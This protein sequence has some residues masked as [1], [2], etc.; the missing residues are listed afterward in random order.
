MKLNEEDEQRITRWIDG[1]LSDSDVADLLSAH[2]ELADEK[3][4]ASALGDLLRQELQPDREADVPHA[5][6]FSH[7]L[8]QRILEDEAETAR[9]GGDSV[10]LREEAQI[11]PLFT[12]MRYAAGIAFLVMLVS[13]ISYGLFSSS[14]AIGSEVV[15]TYTP[16]PSVAATTRYS[17]AADATIIQL[18][19]IPEVPVDQSIAGV[20]PGS[21]QPCGDFGRTILTDHDNGHPLLALAIDGNGRP[22]FTALRF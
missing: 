2:P 16:D 9:A 22:E 7:R 19:G 3:N 15:S 17:A 10:S 21:Y 20:S 18:E 6:F 14:S 5:D 1:E 13:I 8:R 11:L 4:N 12:R